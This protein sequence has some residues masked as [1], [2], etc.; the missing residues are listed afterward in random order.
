MIWAWLT[1]DDTINGV[2][3]INEGLILL[4]ALVWSTLWLLP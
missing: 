2:W 4:N 1:N 3:V